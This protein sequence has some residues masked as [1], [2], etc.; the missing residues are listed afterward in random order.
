MPIGVELL[1]RPLDDAKLVAMAY[2][3]EQSSRPR[4]APS[5]TPPL[6]DGKAPKPLAISVLAKDGKA[7]ASGS[8]TYDATHRALGYAVNVTG[9][10]AS[11]VF[12]MSIDRD[13][14]GKKGPMV[15]H[16]TGP[17]VASARGT[18]TLTE[19][20]RRDLLAGR[21][22]FVVYTR[23]QPTGAMR[24]RLTAAGMVDATAPPPQM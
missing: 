20:E 5:T 14:A 12:T 22:A 15:R 11:H 18:L 19:V 4:R 13:S 23:E 10:L 3:Y 17:G 16:L 8:L 1:G 21:L 6:V 2:D 7:V 24:A 9:L